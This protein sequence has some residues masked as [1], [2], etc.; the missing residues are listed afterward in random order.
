MG[1]FLLRLPNPVLVCALVL[2]GT[3]PLAARADDPNLDGTVRL[4]RI[5]RTVGDTGP[6]A[7]ANALQPRTA[8]RVMQSYDSCPCSGRAMRLSPGRFR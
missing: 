8:G 6:L 7:Q 3:T 2:L 5:G 4:Y 1:T